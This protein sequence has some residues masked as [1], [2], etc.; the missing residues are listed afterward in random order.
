M[1]DIYVIVL[2]NKQH[3]YRFLFGQSVNNSDY[4]HTL[5]TAYD[6]LTCLENNNPEDF[7]SF[8]SNYGYDTDSRRAY[9]TYKAIM[10]EFKNVELL[11]SSEQLE[12]LQEI[13]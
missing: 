9:K 7:E 8:C 13:N 5:P 2:K 10:K 12:Q 6:I 4:G 3:R 11:W 1:R